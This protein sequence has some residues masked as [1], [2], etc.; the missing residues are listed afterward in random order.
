MH[1]GA[2]RIFK[3]SF[4]LNFIIIV[5]CQAVITLRVWYLFP[6]SRI[7][8]CIAITAYLACASITIILAAYYCGAIESFV[9]TLSVDLDLVSPMH[10]PLV[11]Q[12]YIPSLFIH[13]FLF[14]LKIYRVMVCTDSLGNMPL[15]QRFL[16]EGGLM[17]AFATGS[18]LYATIAFSMTSPSGLRSYLSALLGEF[19]VAATVV[20]VCRAM[21]SI[22]SLAATR[23]VD[24]AWLLNH[25]ELSRVNW[26]KG[27]QEGEIRVEIDMDRNDDI[28]LVTR[29]WDID[30]NRTLTI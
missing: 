27:Y 1:Q 2:N 22:R 24:P 4:A 14:S 10:P 5:L 29:N 19:S 28:A 9:N 7:I 11:W 18:I 20:A 30:S 25:A 13:S 3:A 8:R 16:K 26:T 21:L 23:H 6:R 15:L 12:I 17:Y